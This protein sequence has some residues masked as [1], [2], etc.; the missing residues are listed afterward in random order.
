MAITTVD[1]L[2]AGFKP[3]NFFMKAASPT[4]A[5]GRPWTPLLTAGIPGAATA[6]TPGVAGAAQ[7]SLAGSIPF[8]NPAGGQ[9]TYLA[10][11]APT[12]SANAGAVALWDLLWINSGLS[13]TLATAQTVNS[14]AWP[15]RD[16]NGST[17]GDGVYIALLIV[18]ATGAG[19]PTISMSY[20]NSAGTS[21]RTGT[22]IFA[23]GAV[24]PIGA[25]YPLGLQAGDTGVR[26]IQSLTFTSPWASGTFALIAYR[27]IAR[28]NVVSPTVSSTI[29]A[30]SGGLPK[31]YDNSV[32]FPLLVPGTTTA[33]QMAGSVTYAQG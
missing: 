14:A 10:R 6:P 28:V 20:T 17:N 2:I 29:D 25:L 4:L 3:A 1:G 12:I 27:E 7:T 18:G 26:S 13:I 9:S 31:L 24:S 23:T 33:M 16:I 15:A 32:L 30:V 19:T 21:G 8:T 11:F 5:S 22:N